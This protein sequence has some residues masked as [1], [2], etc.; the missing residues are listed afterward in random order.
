[1]T[2]PIKGIPEPES[3]SAL[4]RLLLVL[5]ITIGMLI[6]AYAWTSTEV[7][8]TL[9][10]EPL[11]QEN[12]TRALRELLSPNIFNQER[13]LQIY[14]APFLMDCETGDAPEQADPD[15]SEMVVILEPVCA[16]SGDTITVK[17]LNATVSADARIRWQPPADEEGE[18]AN[19]RPREVLELGREDFVIGSN[20]N[21][22]GTI[23]VPRIRGGEGAIHLVRVLVAVPTGPI[24]LSNTANQ[25]IDRMAQTKR[26]AAVGPGQL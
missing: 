14:E 25:V 19:E 21:F 23:E 7:D 18:E 24:R 22:I 10:Q 2:N 12:L 3:K 15:A 16:D 17:L 4:Q 1:V 9:P 26:H 8:L 13:E 11:R 20:G 6:Y 5:A